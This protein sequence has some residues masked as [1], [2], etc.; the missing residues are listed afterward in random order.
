MR[1]SDWSSDVALP[2][3]ALWR[4]RRGRMKWR[5]HRACGGTEMRTSTVWLSRPSRGAIALATML[6]FGAAHAQ[7]AAVVA[8]TASIVRDGGNQTITPARQRAI[9]DWSAFP[10]PAGRAERTSVEHECV[11]TWRDRWWAHL[12]NQ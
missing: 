7:D 2:I 11:S 5:F 12:S 10:V 4:P 8:G 1:I 9:I 3:Y 6:A